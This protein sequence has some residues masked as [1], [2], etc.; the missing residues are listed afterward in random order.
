[1]LERGQKSSLGEAFRRGELDD[2]RR[3]IVTEGLLMGLLCTR[4]EVV[5]FY[6]DSYF[7]H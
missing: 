3:Y 4:E 6:Q 7:G 2:N 1:M 5:Q